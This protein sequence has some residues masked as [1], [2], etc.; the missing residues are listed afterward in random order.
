MFYK[1]TLGETILDAVEGLAC[2]KY[3]PRSR[4]VLRCGRKD[5]P[6][7]VI[8]D[9]TGRFYHVAGWPA[10][11]DGVQTGGEVT[12]EEISEETYHALVDALNSG[13][14]YH[15]PVQEEPPADVNTEFIREAKVAAMNKACNA[16][17][18]KGFTIRLSD[19]KDYTF[20]LTLE[21]QANIMGVMMQAAMDETAECDYFTSD[22]SCITIPAQDMAAISNFA[23]AFKA[24]HITYYHCLAEWVRSMSGQSEIA[25]VQYG[26][27]VP[28]EFRNEF[29][30]RYAAVVGVSVYAE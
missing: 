18:V 13:E 20:D 10:F 14:P 5:D 4:C 12:V 26:D 6:Q 30:R 15:E 23:T 24:Y 1:A 22:G 2:C 9:R 17:I 19:G 11:P 7:G 3:V 8:L 16:A 21:D 25:A 28:E 29:L 27:V